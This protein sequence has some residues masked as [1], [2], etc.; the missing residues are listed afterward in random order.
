M[1]DEPVTPTEVVA[2][3]STRGIYQEALT[4]LQAS[5][6]DEAKEVIKRRLLEIRR[7][8]ICLEKAK[9]DLAKMLDKNVSEIA[10]LP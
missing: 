5:E 2:P 1:S 7:M 6:R 10:M 8:E 4:E 9:M 3:D